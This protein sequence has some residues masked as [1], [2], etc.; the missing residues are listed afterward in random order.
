MPR[1]KLSIADVQVRVMAIEE[2]CAKLDLVDVRAERYQH[3][4]G[5]AFAESYPLDGEID[6][7]IGADSYYLLVDGTVS[8]G[9]PGTPTAVKT[10]LEWVLCGPAGSQEK[11]PF[12]TS[13]FV[14]TKTENVAFELQRFWELESTGSVIDQCA[15]MSVEDRDAIKTFE[16]YLSFVRERYTVG[17]PWKENCPQLKDNYSQALRRL[18]SVERRLKLGNQSSLKYKEAI[19]QY[20][21]MG[22]S[23]KVKS[24]L[25][26]A[27]TVC[28]LPLHAV[29]KEDKSTTKTIIV[30]DASARDKHGV[31]L[32]DC[33]HQGPA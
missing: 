16:D 3:L 11:A 13:M 30:F 24:D 7:L 26:Q 28:Y 25:D 17:I 8:K 2:I 14:A 23:E 31:S 21:I 19:E 32:N 20:E 22:F 15:K 10:S 5:L 12:T 29:V 33:L 6:V 18:E 27:K 9:P 4:R 1:I